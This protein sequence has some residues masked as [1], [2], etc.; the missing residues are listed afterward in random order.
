M[1]AIL[2]RP[3]CVKAESQ[4]TVDFNDLVYEIEIIFICVSPHHGTVNWYS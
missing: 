2:S 3:Q 4:R 1:V